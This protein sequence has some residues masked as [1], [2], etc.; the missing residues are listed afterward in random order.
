MVENSDKKQL[1]AMFAGYLD[2][3]VVAEMM[4]LDDP[5]QALQLTGK[6]AKV[7]IFYSDIR[8]F[9]AISETMSAEA[10][11]NQLNEY[12]EE[13]CEICFRY[14]GYPDK[15]IGDCLMAI[16]SAPVPRP[17]DALRAVKMGLE[18]QAK[19]REMAARWEAQGKTPFTVGMGLNTGE[20]MMGNLGSSKKMSYTVIGDNVNTAARLY[21]VAA[22]GQIIIS[23]AT[24]EEVKDEVIVNELQ[25]IMVKGKSMP[26]RNF[27]VVG[28]RADLPGVASKMWDGPQEA[29]W[30]GKH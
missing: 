26:L 10:I 13:M 3:D 9:T 17:D 29:V 22:G 30:S 18:Q 27:E 7:T 21:N 19:I 4:K 16:F 12:F 8:S 1:H 28:L 20:V 5:M 2:A 11:Y 23:E 24:H 14:G 25:P 15:F 6:T